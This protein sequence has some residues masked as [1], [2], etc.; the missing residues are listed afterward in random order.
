MEPIETKEEIMYNLLVIDDEPEITRSLKRQFRGKYNVFTATSAMDAFPIL[1]NENIQVVIS[2]QRMPGLT[3]VDFFAKI[4][5]KYPDALKL[6]L[7][8]YSDIEAVIGAINEGQVFRYITK[9]WNPLELEVAIKEAFEKYE[10]ITNNKKLLVKLQD[11]NATLES[12]VKERTA[13]LEALNETL[14]QLNLEK[15]KYIG[16]VA[17]DLRSPIGSA[18]QFSELLYEEFDHFPKQNILQY[19]DFIKKRCEFAL[20][21]IADILDVS[22]IEA[23]IFELK[24]TEANYHDFVK[25]V[26]QQNKILAESKSQNIDFESNL[27]NV[28]F[29]FDKSKMEQVLTN[30]LTNAVKYSLPEKEIKVEVSSTGQQIVT[31]VIDHGLGIPQNELADIFKA[32]KTTSVKATANEKSTGLGL[33]IVKKIVE[34]HEGTIGIESE[35][36]KGTVVTF[37]LPVK[38]D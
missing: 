15:N 13:E 4:K 18:F 22:K 31:R 29:S 27:S 20:D 17:H 32:Y 38:P 26:V 25:E 19:L 35:V 36:G 28:V 30:L 5:S 34:A 21:L 2:D 3:G 6:I 14:T 24:K 8:G 7:T 12:K 37:K 33:A 10:L 1:E 9:P 11:A 23:G 16:I